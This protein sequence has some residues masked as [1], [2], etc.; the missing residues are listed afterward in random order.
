MFAAARKLE[1]L[2]GREASQAASEARLAERA[3]RLDREQTRL[4]AAQAALMQEQEHLQ[5]ATKVAG[6]ARS[7]LPT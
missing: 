2:G 4:D 6:S 1:G 7:C 3:A 5:V